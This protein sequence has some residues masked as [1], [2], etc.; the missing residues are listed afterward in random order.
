MNKVLLYI[1][2]SDGTFQEVDLFEDETITVTSKIQDIRDIAKIF[3]DYSQSFTLPASKK[4][5]KIFKPFYNSN[6]SEGA[7]DASKT[8]DAI[9]HVNYIPLMTGKYLRNGVKM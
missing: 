8:V 6:I 3:T 1:K 7:F 9:T 4:N 5:N 2:D